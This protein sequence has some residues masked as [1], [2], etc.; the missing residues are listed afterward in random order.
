MKIPL[1][2]Q[3]TEYDCGTTTLVNALA[4][5]FDREDI[6]V[7]LLKAIYRYTLDAE[8]GHKG[9][10]VEAMDKLTNYFMK[11]A[12]NNDFGIKCNRYVKEEVTYDVIKKCIDNKGA[13][14]ARCY[15]D[16]EHYVLITNINEDFTYL[17]DPY[18]L[19]EDY[20][21]NDDDISISLNSNFTHNRVVKTTRL[22]SESKD[23]F[24]LMEKEK[25]DIVCIKRV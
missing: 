14:V 24:S 17:F 22:F 3:N 11:Y 13:V 19:E 6:P 21:V 2:F 10:S 20:Y 25:R 18:Y 1:R 5:L 15:M 23:D 16:C 9:T 4:Y 12:S 7:E 8:D